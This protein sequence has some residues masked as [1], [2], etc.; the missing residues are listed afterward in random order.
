MWWSGF[1]WGAPVSPGSVSVPAVGEQEAV[2][3]VS[4]FGRFAVTARSGQGTAVRVVDRMAGVLDGAGVPG[5]ADGRVDLFLD[6]GQIKVVGESHPEGTGKAELAVRPFTT[7]APPVRLSPERR[8]EATLRDLEARS[9]WVDV[10]AGGAVSFEAAG[11]YLGDLRLWRDGVWLVDAAPGCRTFEPVPGAP[12]TDCALAAT[13]EGGVYLLTAY[14]GPGAAWTTD[15]PDEAPFELQWGTPTLASSGIRTGTLPASGFL[16]LKIPK[17]VDTV[18]VALPDVA[19]FRLQGGSGGQPTITTESRRPRAWTRAGEGSIVSLVGA[20]GQPWTLTWFDD[21]AEVRAPRPG[22]WWVGSLSIGDPADVLDPTGLVLS[23]DERRRAVAGATRAVTL[24]S[25]TAFAETF[26]LGPS[27]QLLVEITEEGPYHFTVEGVSASVRVVPYL[28]EWPEGMEPPGA[29]PGTVSLDLGP[30]LYS[31]EIGGGEGIATLT[32][33]YDSLAARAARALGRGPRPQVRRP[34]VQLTDQALG[35]T[36]AVRL[37]GPPGV[38]S[39]LFLREVPLD[40]TDALP[41]WLVPSEVVDTR[42]RVTERGTL[43]LRTPEG[44]PFPVAVDGGALSTDAVVEPGDHRVRLVNPR[45]EVAFATLWLDVP[46]RRPDTPLPPLDPARLASLDAF[47]RLRADRPVGVE[48]VDEV[49][50]TVRL[51]VDEPALYLVESTG[52][53]ATAGALR[54]RTVTSLAEAAG[55]GEGRNF[56]L[57]RFLRPGDYQLTARAESPSQ[58]HAGLRLRKG[59]VR[60]GGD[61]ADETPARITLAPG[62]AVRHTLVVSTEADYQIVHRG[63]TRVF[64]C[65]LEDRDGWTITSVPDQVC[66]VTVHL[67]PGRYVL[68]GLPDRVESRRNTVV[69]RLEPGA[70]PRAGHGPFPLPLARTVQATWA[71]PRDAAERPVDRWELT[72]PAEVDAT[73]S[74]SPEMVARLFA[75]DR[76]LGVA[77][78][79]RSW[80]G[81]LPQGPLRVEVQAA[82]QGTGVPYSLTLEPVALVAGTST[83]VPAEATVA[84]AVGA[85]GV[86]TFESDGFVDVRARLVDAAGRL[87]AANDDRPD[88][89]NFRM[90]TRLDPGR[91]TLRVAP[92][93]GGDGEELTVSM[94]APAEVAG[95]ALRDGAPTAVRPGRDAWVLPFSPGRADVVVATATSRENVGVAI[96][97]QGPDGWRGVTVGTGTRAV[98]VARVDDTP[99]RVRVWSEDG[100]GGEVTVEAFAP[101]SRG[102]GA[103]VALGKGWGAVSFEG[104][105]QFVVRD[106]SEG[107]W[108]CGA[109]GGCAKG[110]EG[111]VDAPATGLVLVREGGTVSAERLRLSDGDAAT[112]RVGA[113]PE[114]LDL[115]PGDGPVVVEVRAASGVLGARVSGSAVPTLVSGSAA[116][117]VSPSGGKVL[118]LWAPGLEEVDARVTM[119][120]LAAPVEEPAADG[121]HRFAVPPNG[122]VTLALPAARH[123][124][125]DLERG[126][127]V[128]TG[129]GRGAWAERGTT[130]VHLRSAVGPVSFVNPTDRE[131]LVRLDVLPATGGAALVPGQPHEGVHAAAETWVVPVPA[132]EGTLEVR[133]ALDAGFAGVDG[134]VARGTSFPVGS[135]GV[136]TMAVAPGPVLAWIETPARP[137]PAREVPEGPATT[138]TGPG[139]VWLS[140]ASVRLDLAP[141]APAAAWLRAP[142]PLVATVEGGASPRVEV[143]DT[144]DRLDVWVGEPS[145]PARVTLRALAGAALFGELATGWSTP[146]ALREGLGPE[147]LLPPG[148]A[149][150]FTLDVTRDGLVGFGA[151]AEAERVDAVL[152]DASGAVLAR[153]L[154]GSRTLAK[155]RYLLALSQP[156]G[157]PPVRARPVVVGL[158]LPPQGPPE[159]VVRAYLPAAP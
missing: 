91:Y 47:P 50:Q 41:V 10:P 61:I 63:R 106:P 96:E 127:A 125:I 33:G 95:P 23:T 65:R 30:G 52:L 34:A 86:Y 109:P 136:L 74:V 89:W 102:S 68:V 88:D 36:D 21:G 121:E 112:L 24:S 146:V 80:T 156:P 117:A 93:G 113:R 90:S 131:R 77:A 40:P 133:G 97:V 115:E 158:D 51:V 67:A 152:S 43:T 17:G 159:D 4:E 1:A 66:D 35:P 72:S 46:S 28:D 94:R 157:A 104:P 130:A 44:D 147:V 108:V 31:V 155:G 98:A 101:R 13:L 151:R 70:A 75:G 134:R 143:L 8:V 42:I 79:G 18:A 38:A 20:P 154:V 57:A 128:S 150:W 84:V 107:T 45:A 87:V 27:A 73:L 12:W 22:A 114:A 149:A 135:G 49:P 145:R 122:A 99:V 82:R 5:E 37:F 7:V 25:A 81:T 62:E 140:G 58:G 6:R 85:P 60:D 39:G 78:A 111:P 142:C 129:D 148:G 120:A 83:T 48:L 124:R 3:T 32:A 138:V 71:E 11:R 118:E 15:A 59:V 2:F 153:G 110:G 14:G 55:N 64:D 29:S 26:N 9:W 105:G 76:V 19:P 56:Q 119:H 92:V 69:R 126:V 132:A 53:L 139:A 116:L 137:G 141:P 54:T 123:L 144:G 16:R 103:A 100:R